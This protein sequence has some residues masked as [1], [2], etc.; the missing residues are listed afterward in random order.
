[1]EKA[2]NDSQKPIEKSH[3]TKSK[4]SKKEVPIYE[5]DSE[6]S[7]DNFE[8]DEMK[9]IFNEALSEGDVED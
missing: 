5:S 9:D 7:C 6:P 4:K 3:T 8:I 2:I 1:M